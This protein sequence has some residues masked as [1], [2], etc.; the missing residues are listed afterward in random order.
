MQ[1]QLEKRQ[2]LAKVAK[3]VT[4]PVRA[5]I[6]ELLKTN[7]KYGLTVNNITA[8][9]RQEKVFKGEHCEQPAIS[10]HLKRLLDV[11]IVDYVKQ[12][13]E[14]IYFVKEDLVNHF[15]YVCTEWSWIHQQGSTAATTPPLS[16]SSLSTPLVQ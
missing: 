7:L 6:I 5:Y 3:A 9:C 1:N 11:D 15:D 2:N 12:G 14:H 13:K 10:A 8:L 4:H 16:I